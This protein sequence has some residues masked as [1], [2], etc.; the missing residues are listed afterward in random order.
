MTEKASDKQV[1]GRHYKDMAIQPIHFIRANEL[2][3]YEANIVKYACRHA[4]KNGRQDIEK[5]IHYAELLLEEYDNGKT[6]NASTPDSSTTSDGPDPTQQDQSGGFKSV[7][8][9]SRG[10][11]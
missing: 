4:K 7:R 5:V 11:S 1:G 9:T 10:D 3:W 2:G 8:G 6:Y